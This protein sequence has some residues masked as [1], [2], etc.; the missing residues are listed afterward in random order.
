MSLPAYPGYKDSGADWLGRVP[1]HWIIHSV[2][3]HLK[4]IF[5]GLSV[6]QVDFDEDTV[7]VTRIETISTGNIDHEKLGY[8]RIEDARS[9]RVLLEGDILFSNIN[10]LK[11]IG[12]C[13]QYSPGLA[14]YAGMNL[15]VLRPAAS[16]NHS[17]LF[18]LGRELIKRLRPSS[19]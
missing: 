15:L 9:D 5:N 8:I 17:W 4:S 18:W 19:S 14:I 2:R 3:H 13:A 11:M 12:N 16:V 6:E 7:P 1:S 10:S